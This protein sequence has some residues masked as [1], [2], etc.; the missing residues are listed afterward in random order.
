MAK[1]AVR[2]RAR[3]RVQVRIQGGMAARCMQAV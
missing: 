2:V 1:I 3:V